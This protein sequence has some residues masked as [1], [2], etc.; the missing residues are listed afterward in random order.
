MR[1]SGH[2]NPPSLSLM[3]YRPPP[4]RSSRAPALSVQPRA[5][6]LNFLVSCIS[7]GRW[8]AG[9][10]LALS[11]GRR[12]TPVRSFD[13]TCRSSYSMYTPLSTSIPHAHHHHPCHRKND[14]GK[15]SST[16]TTTTVS[17]LVTSPSS[18][19][20]LRLPLRQSQP[21]AASAT[22]VPTPA[23]PARET[24]ALSERRHWLLARSP[25]LTFSVPAARSTR[26][27]NRRIC[28]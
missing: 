8:E 20:P 19:R 13:Q 23:T 15:G 2:T 4:P 9:V 7:P 16:M 11:R 22:A 25:V 27:E 1:A 24:G 14:K 18:R 5:P 21:P 3:R 10:L 28:L 6:L 26:S 12:T 17:S